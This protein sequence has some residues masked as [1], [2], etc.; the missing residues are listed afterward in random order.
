[1]AHYKDLYG[2]YNLVYKL[3]HIAEA[4]YN[5]GFVH[6]PEIKINEQNHLWNII[7]ASCIVF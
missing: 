1:M 5:F 6:D 7:R 3:Y 2:S 4:V